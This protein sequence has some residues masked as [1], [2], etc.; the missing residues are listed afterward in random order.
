VQTVR[1]Y[2]DYLK[3]D[4][5]VQQSGRMRRV[6]SC[7]LRKEFE[8][9]IIASYAYF[10]SSFSYHEFPVLCLIGRYVSQQA[11]VPCSLSARALSEPNRTE[12][13]PIRI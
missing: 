9:E 12:V 5:V 10:A 3:R 1:T 6:L 11:S 4:V 8:G 13:G 7:R 2:N